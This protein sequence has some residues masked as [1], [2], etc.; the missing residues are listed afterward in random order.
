M[1]SFLL[2]AVSLTNGHE[3]ERILL[4]LLDTINEYIDEGGEGKRER[5]RE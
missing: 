2:I 1:H 5:E 4:L 3:N